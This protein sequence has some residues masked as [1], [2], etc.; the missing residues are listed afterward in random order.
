MVKYLGNWILLVLALIV[1]GL[2][3]Y[4]LRPL[5]YIICWA[6]I[7][8]FFIYPVYKFVN[9]KLKNHRRISAILVIFCF[10]I[11]IIVPLSLVSL[12]FYSQT[13]SFL[14]SLEPLTKKDLTEIIESLK[15]YPYLYTLIYKIIN[16][17]QPYLPQL[18]EKFVQFISNLFQSGFVVLKFV[19]SI[20]SFGFQ[21]A[22]TLITLYYFLIDG[23]KAINEIV[24]LI[25]GEKEEKEKILQRV[26]FILK[27][28]LY[29]NILTGLIQGFLAFI[30]YFTLG[31][32]H[33]LLWAFLTVIASFIP[34]LG[35]G[36]IWGPLFIYLLIIGSYIKAFI[37]L[38][39]SVLIIAQVDNF[40]KPILIGGKTGIHNL[41][42]FF[43]VLGGLAQFGFLGLFLGPVILGLVLSIIE[44]YKIKIPH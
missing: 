25:P 7:I 39:Y 18:Q 24:E 11:F 6:G 30:I 19:K 17:I 14:K 22:F 8:A 28:V 31:I 36:F 20:F 34:I 16:Q 13:L 43:S 38:F 27:G 3:I 12:N 23:E 21:L 15:D 10:L 26:S 2:F 29:G 5:F 37:L 42:I 32:P 40:L 4:L 35:T 9:L 41:L 44:I 33:Y 1:L